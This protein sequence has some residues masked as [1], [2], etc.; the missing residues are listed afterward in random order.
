MSRYNYPGR[1]ALTLLRCPNH[2]VGWWLARE[3]AVLGTFRDF[4]RRGCACTVRPERVRSW[5]LELCD[6]DALAETLTNELER[7]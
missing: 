5:P 4:T 1:H 3:D 6:L 2:R 7:A